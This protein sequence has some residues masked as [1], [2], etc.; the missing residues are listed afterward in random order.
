MVRP[1]LGIIPA[2]S[3][4]KGIPGKNLISLAGK[5]LL[6]FTC[7]QA[8]ASKR[9]TRTILSTDAQEIAACAK[10]HGVE[11]PFLRPSSLAHDT[12]TM[13]E[14]L[15]QALSFL[16]EKEGYR[17]EI[18]VLLQPTSPLR[19]AEQIDEAVDLLQACSADSVVSV[20][21]VPHQFTPGSILRLESGRL[22]PYQEGPQI[23]RRQD[24]PVLYARNGPAILAVRT[25]VILKGNSLYGEKCLPLIM[26]W[27]TSVDIDRPSDL[28]LAEFLLTS[29]R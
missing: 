13:L 25:D 9:L 22:V 24:K 26:S 14:V 18:T 20:M 2:R 1:I 16:Q 7:E 4:S 15:K 10:K 6:T 19:R 17:P 12:T 3:G 27:E 21:E 23:L 28:L 29:S 11:A 5:P 8:R